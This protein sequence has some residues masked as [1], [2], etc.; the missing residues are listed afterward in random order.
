MSNH[1][2][3][4]K[5]GELW[6]C[7]FPERPDGGRTRYQEGCPACLVALRATLHVQG[8]LLMGYVDTDAGTISTRPV[9][10]SEAIA[11]WNADA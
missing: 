2:P 7:E 8:D 3:T 4:P 9:R 5:R 10:A 6:A 11:T 1:G